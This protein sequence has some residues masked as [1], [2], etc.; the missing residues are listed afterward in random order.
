MQRFKVKIALALLISFL[1]L[2]LMGCGRPLPKM[3]DIK[4]KWLSIKKE[5]Y[6]LG[7]GNTVGFTIEFFDDKTIMVPYGKGTWTIL[8]DGRLR[9]EVAN[10]LMHGEIDQGILTITMPKDQ[11]KVVFKKQ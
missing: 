1:S 7:G 11:E 6:Q 9:I 2:G 8:K 4:G 5:A 10:I 3:E